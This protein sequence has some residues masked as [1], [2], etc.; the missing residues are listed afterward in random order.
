MKELLVGSALA[1]G[2]LFLIDSAIGQ[3]IDLSYSQLRPLPEYPREA[4]IDCVTG[5]VL[6]KFTVL[7]NGRVGQAEIVRSS[8]NGVFDQVV[9]EALERWTVHASKGT[10]LEKLF[11]FDLGFDHCRP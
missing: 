11:E 7:E 4:A 3:D 2:T 8:P 5:E 9:L 6:A 1:F 10:E